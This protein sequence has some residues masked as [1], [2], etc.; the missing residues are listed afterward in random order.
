MEPTRLH[1][2]NGDTVAAHLKLVRPEDDILV[3]RE[4]LTDGP[5][6]A[7]LPR[8]ELLRLRSGYFEKELGVPADKFLKFGQEQQRR[9]EQADRFDEVILWFEHDLFDRTI[10]L[11][12]LHTLAGLTIRHAKLMLIET[13]RFPGVEPFHG[14]GQLSAEQL[15]SLWPQ[16]R[17][18]TAEELE[19]GRLGWEAYASD[20][21]RGIAAWLSRYDAVMPLTAAAL[22]YHL[23]RF[24]S[25]ANG[26][27]RVEQLTLELVAAGTD[28][29]IELFARFSASELAY[30]VGDL[31]FWR[32]VGRLLEGDAPLLCLTAAAPTAVPGYAPLRLPRFEES[33]APLR[34]TKLG[35]TEAGRQV[36]RGER[37]GL[38]AMGQE[39]WLGGVRLPAGQ[40]SQVWRWDSARGQLRLV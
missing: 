16:R 20:D 28:R 34:A 27:G 38:P 9:L 19:I 8:E 14:M 35:L 6:S 32:D 4:M 18:V 24:P 33:P 12:L 25:A 3:W 15:A 39:R 5:L 22:R 37:D 17:S 11:Y 10:L 40:E 29:P 13:D 23:G 7:K 1:L 31:Q 30:G 26:L 21:P 2:V 36:L